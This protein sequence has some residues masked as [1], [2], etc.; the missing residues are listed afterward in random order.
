MAQLGEAIAR[1]H[2]LFEQDG[3]RD[4]SWADELQDRMRQRGLVHS[5]R[6]VTPVLRPHFISRK[7]LE[8]LTRQ[9]EQLAAI[10]A[11]FKTAAFETP[12]FSSRLQLLP[13]EKMLASLPSALPS[14]CITSCMDAKLQNGSLSLAGYCTCKPTALAFSEPLADLFLDLPLLKAFKRDRYRL[15]KIGAGKRLLAAVLQA[16]KTFGGTHQPCIAVVEFPEPG[17]AISAES[18]LL[19]DLFNHAGVSARVTPPEALTYSARRLRA[20]DFAIDIVFRRF[21]ARELLAHS[22]LSHPL[23]AAY[24][25]RAVCVVNDFRSEFANRRA[26]FELLTDEAA[27]RH[28]DVADRKL[29]RQTVPWTRVVTRR[30]TKYHEEEIDLLDFILKNRS[31]LVLRPNED[32][33]EHRVFIGAEMSGYGWESA[34]RIALRTPYVVQERSFGGRQSVPLYQYGELQMKEAEVSVHPQLFN[35]RMQG[36]SAALETCSAGCASPLAITPVL[37]LERS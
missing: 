29:I 15:S 23:I 25:D 11:R 33:D 21:Q 18:Q 13:A 6:L 1:Y 12:A 22:D 3:F 7:Q 31:R 26:L 34:L 30:K 19:A 35:G 4:L 24:R 10:I 28:L 32:S 8:A 14:T 2:K 17:A 37:L 5:G 27:N 20:G 16:W 9:A 36:A